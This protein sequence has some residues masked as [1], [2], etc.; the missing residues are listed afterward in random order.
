MKNFKCIVGLHKYKDIKTQITKG[1]AYGF[2]GAE[3]PGYRI[4]QICEL[5]G[6][7]NYMKL[8]LMMPDKDLYNEHI[9]SN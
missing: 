7:K 2:A 1:I 6:K 9:W 8:N 5:C 4:I 3:L